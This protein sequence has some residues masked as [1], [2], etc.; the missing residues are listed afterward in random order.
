MVRSEE[1]FRSKGNCRSPIRGRMTIPG[2]F[3]SLLAKFIAFQSC[4]EICNGTSPR[5]RESKVARGHPLSPEAT[6]CGCARFL[7]G[8]VLRLLPTAACS[9]AS[10]EH[11]TTT[12]KPATLRSNARRFSQVIVPLGSLSSEFKT[13]L[14][15]VQDVCNHPPG[16]VIVV[17]AAFCHQKLSGCLWCSNNWAA[18][19]LLLQNRAL[20]KI[21]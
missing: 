9:V 3:R 7:S 21:D 14:H 1:R 12:V 2:C 16:K 4:F 5:L 20:L 10:E 18:T 11:H 13:S 6:I 15:L 19:G 17:I 8:V